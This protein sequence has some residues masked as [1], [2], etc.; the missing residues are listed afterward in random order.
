MNQYT[1]VFIGRE[2]TAIGVFHDCRI[3]V[4]AENQREAELMLYDTHE[5]IH[6]LDCVRVQPIVNLPGELTP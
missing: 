4:I 1:F 5:H 6:S 2:K 3:S